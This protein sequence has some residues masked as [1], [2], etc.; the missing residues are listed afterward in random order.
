MTNAGREIALGALTKLLERAERNPGTK[1]SIRERLPVGS[2][3]SEDRDA[4]DE[5]L[6][7]AADARAVRLV[8]GKKERA[9]EIDYVELINPGPLYPML[10]RQP[11]S[12][13]AD[14]ALELIR[15]K[16]NVTEPWSAFI[17]ILVAGWRV[18]NRPY[19]IGTEEAEE[20]ALALIVAG[21]LADGRWNGYDMRTVS[22]KVAAQSKWLESHLAIVSQVLRA[23]GVVPSELRAEDAINYLGVAKFPHP[24]LIS[25]PIALDGQRVLARPYAG[26]APENLRRLTLAAEPRYVLTIENFAS[27]NRHVRELLCDDAVVLYTAG[28][29]STSFI[30]AFAKLASSC[31]APIFHWGDIDMAGLWIAEHLA[32]VS[33][34][35]LRLHRMSSELASELGAPGV[36]SHTETT[37][38]TQELSALAEFLGSADVHWLEQEAIDPA[39]PLEIQ[40][41]GV[42]GV[43]H[44]KISSWN[45]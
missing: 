30:E 14:L 42:H 23:A 21:E 1:R 36:Q 32:R 38:S 44:G 24:C 8:P 4:R 13:R 25:G 27:F 40:C 39:S 19:G 10:G 6:T 3:L 7:A 22:T 35:P 20:V 18:G 34:R 28:F 41:E 33:P 37:W 29:P 16:V 31:S 26:I 11:A 5:L 15:K 9:S 12:T 2:L 45:R 17:D 43:Q